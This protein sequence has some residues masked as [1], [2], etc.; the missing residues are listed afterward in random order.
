MNPFPWCNE[1]CNDGAKTGET[2]RYG[3]ILRIS[4]LGLGD[5]PRYS[6]VWFQALVLSREWRF[7]SSHPHQ[8][9]KD[10]FH[11]DRVCGQPL[12]TVTIAREIRKTT[13]R[14]LNQPSQKT[15][16]LATARGVEL[17]QPVCHAG[18]RN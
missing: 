9:L 3:F 7:K 10:L 1:H 6:Q 12:R 2:G 14:S 18:V 8:I 13:P 4:G 15:K 17:R 11:F 5:T 16:Q